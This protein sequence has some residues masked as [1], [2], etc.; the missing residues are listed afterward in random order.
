MTNFGIDIPQRL[1]FSFPQQ[2][3]TAHLAKMLRADTLKTARREKS[4][5]AGLLSGSQVPLKRKPL[6]LD[7]AQSAL[8][9]RPEDAQIGIRIGGGLLRKGRYQKAR[10]GKP[11]QRAA[12]AFAKAWNWHYR[13][14]R[15][16]RDYPLRASKQPSADHLNQV[17]ES[18]LPV[19]RAAGELMLEVYGRPGH[20]VATKQDLSPVTDADLASHRVITQALATLTPAWPVVSEEDATP[21]TEARTLPPVFWLLDPLDGT[22][23]FIAR[24]DE[25]CIS[26]GL[27]A[28]GL[29]CAGLIFGPVQDLLY[30]GGPSIGARRKRGAGA[31]ESIRART[32][33]EE[34]GVLI[35]SRRHAAQPEGEHF[36]RHEVLGSALKFGR[37]AEGH[38]DVY[39]RRG[40]TMEWDTCAGQA[41]LEG[42]GG[43][44]RTLGGRVQMRYGKD[45]FLNPGF[46]AS[47]RG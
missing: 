29:A 45:G 2:V 10:E 34:G 46:M 31:W 1:K 19:L 41:I 40:N 37:L 42:A 39:L 8:V 5:Q 20:G 4:F 32:R 47:G 38:A 16:P 13:E 43:S 28:H 23:E 44:V 17:L 25:F 26:L 9:R 35:S 14:S 3:K 27:A 30:A 22:R 36:E 11:R 12:H 7:V 15:H 24:T 33:P 18:L 21:M 6:G